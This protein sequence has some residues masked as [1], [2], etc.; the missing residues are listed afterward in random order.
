MPIDDGQRASFFP[1]ADAAVLQ[2]E[3]APPTV[4]PDTVGPVLDVEHAD[5]AI[6]S[7]S[8]EVKDVVYPP[9]V[10]AFEPAKI[11]DRPM[12]FADRYLYPMLTENERL[13][14]T[15]L[16]YYTRGILEDG[17]LLSRLQEK[18]YL[19]QETIGWEFVIVG[20]LDHNSYTRIVT[21]GLPLVIEPSVPTIYIGN[22]G[23]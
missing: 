13:R 23:D 9:K 22:N 18:V 4:R 11:P 2:S 16:W 10:H 6:H 1:K 12:C 19:A 7:W 15:M 8:Q 21:V 14:L 20:L 3:Y 5:Q 17:E